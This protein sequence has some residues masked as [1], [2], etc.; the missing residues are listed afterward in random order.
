MKPPPRKRTKPERQRTPD[1]P[2]NA[3][4]GAV[5]WQRSELKNLLKALQILYVK[6]SGNGD[7]DFAYLKKHVPTRSITELQT[8][9]DSLK[10]SVLSLV[11][12]KLNKRRLEEESARKPIDMWTQM[13][14]T[15]AGSRE[16]A[17][18]A[19]FSQILM[20]SS[21]EP[22]TLR[23]CDPPHI[24]VRDGLGGCTLPISPMPQMPNKVERP[25]TSGTRP[26]LLPKTPGPAIGPGRR[27][28]ASAA[29]TPTP[30][31]PSTPSRSGVAVKILVVPA[32]SPQPASRTSTPISGTPGS[33]S[34]RPVKTQNIGLSLIQ[35]PQLPCPQTPTTISASSPSEP[36]SSSPHTPIPSSATSQA[37][38]PSMAALS[39]ATTEPLLSTPAAACCGRFGCTGDPRKCNLRVSGVMGVVDFEKIYHYLSCIHQ[40]SN[41]CDLTPM[42]SAIMLDLLMSLPEELPL[43]DCNKLHKHL[44]QMYQFLSSTADSKMAQQM[45]EELKEGLCAGGDEQAN[46]QPSPA[47]AGVEKNMQPNEAES[48][49]S[50]STDALGQSEDL[51]LCPALNPFMVPLKLL[52]RK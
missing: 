2:P 34:A 28:S 11:S 31:S 40:P 25:G 13:A 46:S 17:I 29:S 50:G 38:V 16:Q 35:A 37:P 47:Q 4:K 5:Q 22:C 8:L 12:Y 30:Q 33:G 9:V 19:A 1:P 52:M 24:L 48:Q 10:D 18:T 6:S 44:I 43:L 41:K 51:V 15:V 42:E 20:V 14:S 45:F 7:I 23:N 39:S 32:P 21:T 49:S 27:L 3:R 26:V 36:P